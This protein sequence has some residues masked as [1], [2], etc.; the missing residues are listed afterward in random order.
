MLKAL[1]TF[2]SVFWLLG[3]LVGLHGLIHIFGAAALV[4]FVADQLVEATTKRS[5]FSARDGLAL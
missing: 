1:A 3:L 2:F 4:F 5:R